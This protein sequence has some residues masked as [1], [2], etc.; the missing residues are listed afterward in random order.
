M[1]PPFIVSVTQ[2]GHDP[3]NVDV[4]FNVPVLLASAGPLTA[5]FEV[6]GNPADTLTAQVN[7][8]TIEVSGGDWSPDSTG[9]PWTFNGATTPF[10]NG[11]GVV[12]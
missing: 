5:H 1:S 10:A 9:Q 2:N 6:D 11:S 3:Q 7:P 12:L 4:Q 8:T